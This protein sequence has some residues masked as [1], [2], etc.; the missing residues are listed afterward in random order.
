M[1]SPDEIR[2][3]VSDLIQE[4][5]QIKDAMGYM[6]PPLASLGLSLYAW[7]TMV[8]VVHNSLLSR[9]DQRQILDEYSAVS[10]LEAEFIEKY[11]KDELPEKPSADEPQPLPSN[12]L[13]F[14]IKI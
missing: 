6:P 4:I 5:G 3:R 14:K 10:S 12:I 11:Y 8:Q 13:E 2:N 1:L 7:K 9:E